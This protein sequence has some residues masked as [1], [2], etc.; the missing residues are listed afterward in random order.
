MRSRL[1]IDPQDPSGN[2][3]LNTAWDAL[4]TNFFAPSLPSSLPASGHGGGNPPGQ[5]PVEIPLT[6]LTSEAVQASGAQSGATSVV[7]MTS[8]GITINLLYDTAA[9]NAPSSF[10]A[11]IQQAASILTATISDKITVNIKIDYSGTGGGAA[12]GPDN[13][14]YENYSTVRTDLINNATPGDPT[15]NALPTGSTIQGQSQVAVWNAQLKLWGVLG[16]SDISTDDG[17][18]TF[19][20]DISS[21][22]LLGVALHELT[23][24]M[25]R[26]HYGA[27]YGPQPDIFDLFRFTSP[28]TQLINGASTAPAAYFS[29][30]GGNTKLADYGRTSDPSDFLNSGVQGGNDP[31][32]EFYT[33]STLQSLTAADK[34]QLDALG[35]HLTSSAS[36]GPNLRLIG[37]GDFTAGG[38]A[39]LAWQNAGG[40]TLWNS[41]GSALTEVT[42]PSASMG[43][44]WSAYGVGDFNGDGIADLLWT[45]NSGQVAIWE[46]KGSNLVGFGVPAGKMGT[47]WHIAGIGDFNGSGD[48]D[49]LWVSTAGQAAVWTMSGT[50]L[51]GFAISNGSMGAEWYVAATGDF[52]NDGH[53][54]VLWANTSGQVDIWEMN[55]AKLSGFVQNVGQMGADWK[56]AGVGHFNGAADSTSDVVWVNSFTNHVQIWQMQ[57]GEVANIINPSGLYGTEWH[58]EAVGNF[59]GDASSDLLWISN[60]GAASI[61]EISGASVQAISVS[62]PTGNTLQLSNSVAAAAA[63]VEGASTQ[64]VTEPATGALLFNGISS[65]DK[66]TVS[67]SLEN[68][69]TGY[70]GNFTVGA[71]DTA[72]GQDSVGWQFNF[73]SS[74]V[75]RTATQTYDVKVTDHSADGTNNTVSQAVSVTIGAPGSDTFVFKPGFGANVIVNPKTS[76][77][78]E[79]DGFASASS[80]HELQTLLQEAQNSE[81]QSMFQTANG[82]HDTVI[83][84]GN[85]DSITLLNIKVADLHAS[86]FIIHG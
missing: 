86:N 74:A 31:F 70:L 48:S 3:A 77:T 61:W 78:I 4:D 71:L 2:G 11:G 33:G 46:M 72:S 28:G 69:G 19:A 55:G 52:N 66:N 65:T 40:V 34:E 30:D 50:A 32:N 79:L 20:T 47:E 45:N 13:G 24:A 43:S 29:V 8:G 39:D 41:S 44:E 15:F 6:A 38:N 7:A 5:R 81:S 57:N 21:G 36:G 23:H 58:L 84:L 63:Q 35:F 60:S 85:H 82:G 17:S 1:I 10:R 42:V 49:I 54:D 22:L 27:P 76:D 16:A 62:A 26:V 73:D 53:R 12:A 80:I 68:G 18:A 83:N 59:A 25:G 56:I 64:S 37:A 67:V 9:M 51:A 14:Y 75:T